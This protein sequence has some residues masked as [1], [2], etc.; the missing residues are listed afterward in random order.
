MA[1][2]I[3][4]GYSYDDVL[5]VPKYSELASRRDVKFETRISKNFKIDTPIIAAN[6][7][8]ICESKMAI[9]LGRL[10][11]L[12]VIHRLLSIEHQAEEVQKVKAQK[13]IAAAA[14]GVKD[15]EE[16]AKALVSAGAD[17]LV[18][19]VA[20][21][22]SKRG[23]QALYHLKNTYPKV[24][25][26]VGNIATAE[27][28]QFFLNLNVD[29]LKVGIGPSVTHTSWSMTGVGVPQIS[30]IMDVMKATRGSVP[31]CA[32]GGIKCPG[33]LVK[34]IGAGADTVMIGSLFAGTDETPGEVII[35]KDGD[36]K[37]Y[38]RLS[39]Y[40]ALIKK[41]M[42]DGQ[43]VCEDIHAEGEVTMIPC[44]GPV[45]KVVAKLLGGLAS[46]MSLV[47]AR[48][49]DALRGKA[50]FRE[51]VGNDFEDGQMFGSKRVY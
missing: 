4:K 22:H 34:A 49:I 38:R 13:L 46:G 18:L 25:V 26:I 32:D 44:R 43:K 47:G 24:D 7:D 36:F 8:T 1:K 28:A 29:G 35:E 31:I 17:I 50:E 11:G 14:I 15:L 33:D 21:A 12:G 37:E 39:S 3:N 41:T 23:G 9:T 45:M 51:I 42:L 20:H 27:A 10:G 16:R 48:D 40:L 30:A 2:I 19:D 6:L 5:I